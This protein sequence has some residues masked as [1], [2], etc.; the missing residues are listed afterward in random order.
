VLRTLGVVLLLLAG[1]AGDPTDQ[2]RVEAALLRLSDFP[3]DQGWTVEPAATDD[4]AQAEFEAT[5]NRC[6]RDLDPTMETR[7]AERDSDSFTRGGTF[8]LVSSTASVVSDEA[9]RDQLFD[10]LEPMVDCFG[11]VLQDAL[12]TELPDDS[13]V[14]VTDRYPLDVSTDAERT[15]GHAIQLEFG[16]GSFFVDVVAIEQGPTLLYGAFLHQGELTLDDEEQILAPAVQRI[17][18]L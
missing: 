4:P 9:V 5:L 1:C 11:T 12:T 17:K 6:E 7:S 13:T 15:E 16:V 10:A 8:V 18:E 3:A 2:E 14:T